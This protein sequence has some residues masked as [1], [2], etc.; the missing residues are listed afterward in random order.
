MLF[1]FV[2]IVLIFNCF[3]KY[4]QCVLVKGFIVFFLFVICYCIGDEI[5]FLV[6]WVN[7]VDFVEKID[8]IEVLNGF[9]WV[10]IVE[11]DVSVIL[12]YMS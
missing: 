7:F 4:D 12:S 10:F 1:V 11:K 5:I 3:Y 2:V 8:V 6:I 9:D